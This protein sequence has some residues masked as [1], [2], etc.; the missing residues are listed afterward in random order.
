MIGRRT[1]L[2]AALLGC[3]LAWAQPQGAAS[4]P[5]SSPEISAAERLLFVDNHLKRLRP[6]R[7][8]RYRFTHRETS[9]AATFDDD[10]TLALKAD[11][12][13]TCCAVQ[14]RFLSGARQVNLPDIDAAEANP[15]TLYFLEREVR[16]MQRLTGGQAAHFRR[17]IRIALAETAPRATTVRHGGRDVAAQEIAIA[18]YSDDPMRHRF[19]RQADTRYRFVLSPEVPGTL[20]RI[21]ADL[22]GTR[23]DTLTLLETER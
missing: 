18:P 15:V 10:V 7:Q 1:A 11:P 4:A 9:A 19:E 5:G 17:R 20:L 23:T 6:P 22:P 3:P 12:G 21:E 14:G 16:E 2:G 13:G 8:L